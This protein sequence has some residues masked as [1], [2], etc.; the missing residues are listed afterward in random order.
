MS[1]RTEGPTPAGG[2]YAIVTWRDGDGQEC[3]SADAVGAEIVEYADDDSELIRTYMED[4]TPAP[5]DTRPAEGHPFGVEAQDSPEWDVW[6][7][8]NGQWLHLTQNLAELQGALQSLQVD[9]DAELFDALSTLLGLPAWQGA[10][11]ALKTDVY[12]WMETHRRE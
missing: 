8:E 12:A 10:P 5:F 9:T 6:H 7:I 3:E 1:E 2:A 4:P 11:E